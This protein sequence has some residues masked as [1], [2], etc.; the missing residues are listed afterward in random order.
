MTALNSLFIEKTAVK[1]DPNAVELHFL[2]TQ[3]KV[4]QFLF[5]LCQE[6]Q[7]DLKPLNKKV[8][9]DTVQLDVKE[10]K[11]NLED[12]F[13]IYC[14]GMPNENVQNLMINI[15]KNDTLFDWTNQ[16]GRFRLERVCYDIIERSKILQKECEKY[17][18]T[19]FD[20][21]GNRQE[22]LKLAIE[23]IK[24]KSINN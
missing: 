19:F 6:I 1:E 8:I 5:N 21:S 10:A 18:I 15:R 22:K 23:E 14:L 2:L 9:L 24:K 7:F 12:D 4:R 16:I 17:N 11:E 20:T 3:D 13:D